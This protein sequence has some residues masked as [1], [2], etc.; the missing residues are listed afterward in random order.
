MIFSIFFVDIV[1]FGVCKRCHFGFRDL[2]GCPVAKLY[3]L[4]KLRV[5]IV[6]CSVNA[7]RLVSSAYCDKSFR[8]NDSCVN[9]LMLIV[10]NLYKGFDAYLT[11]ETCSVFLD[12]SKA[13]DKVWHQGLIFK[14]K[15]IGV[16]N[17]L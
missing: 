16:L 10:L 6:D 14:L 15:S 2:D 17:S 12:M 9:Q 11:L 8:S 13:F 7:K 5:S 3:C 4:R 1:N